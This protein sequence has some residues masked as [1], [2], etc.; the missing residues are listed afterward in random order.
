[1]QLSEHIYIILMRLFVCLQMKLYCCS[2]CP[3]SFLICSY[4][5]VL[6]WTIIDSFRKKINKKILYS[7]FI[8]QT[9]IISK[10]QSYPIKSTSLP[11]IHPTNK[12]NNPFWI[13][14][15]K[16]FTAMRKHKVYADPMVLHY[17]LANKVWSW[18]LMK[19]TQLS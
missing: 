14:D 8:F 10:K 6:K 18:V 3:N 19:V 9:E 12:W 5:G 16:S 4:A 15:I 1:M 13:F 2:L 17:L 11:S 7:A